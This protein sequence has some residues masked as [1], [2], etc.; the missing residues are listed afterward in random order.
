MLVKCPACNASFAL[1]AAL[2]V[3]AGRSALMKALAMPA[4]LARAL[5]AYLGMFRAAGR[6]LNFDRAEKILS[7]L[8]PMLESQTVTRNNSMRAAPLAVWQAGFD[9]MIEH[10]DAGKLDLP[11]KSHGYLLEIV[12][13]LADKVEAK[14]ERDVEQTRQRGQ[15]RDPAADQRV[16]RNWKVSRIRGDL[17]LG[18]I[19]R[20]QA[21]EQLLAAGIQPEVLN[22]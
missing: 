5:A 14:T 2:A 18:L 4:P 16:E 15:H 22:G 19:T 13:S 9:R 21:T 6:A 20:E 17:D 3:D 10:R 1:E 7:D 12:F 11:L 8:Q